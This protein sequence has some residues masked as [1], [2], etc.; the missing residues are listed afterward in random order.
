MISICRENNICLVVINT[1]IGRRDCIEYAKNQTICA[2]LEACK[3]AKCVSH[4]CESIP[5]IHFRNIAVIVNKRLRNRPD[6]KKQ[7]N[8][9]LYMPLQTSIFTQHES[10]VYCGEQNTLLQNVRIKVMLSEGIFQQFQRKAYFQQ[11]RYLYAR[12]DCLNKCNLLGINLDCEM[13]PDDDIEMIKTAAF[14]HLQ[15]MIFFQCGE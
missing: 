6:L 5:A 10:G 4:K 12:N 2:T 11:Y 7:L 15:H 9:L 3:S 1:V 14:K 13:V 8:P